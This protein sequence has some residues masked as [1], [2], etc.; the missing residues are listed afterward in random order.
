MKNLLQWAAVLLA[1]ASLPGLAPAHADDA[2]PAAQAFDYTLDNGMRVIV[3]PDHRA[4]VVVTMVWYRVGA[5]DEKTGVTG[6]AHVLEHMMFKGTPQVPAG[7]FSRLIAAAGGRENA[8]T[9]LDATAYFQTLQK[10]KLALALKLEAD[11]MANLTLSP[12]EFKR[13]IQVVMEERRWRVEDQSRA[14][15]YEQLMAT[16]FKEHPYRRPGIGWMNDL[17]HMTVGDVRD[18][19]ERWYAPNN[20]I[21][22]VVGDVEPQEVLD[23]AKQS[24]GPVPSRALP[25]R[26]AQV[27]PPQRGIQRINVKAPAELPYLV[28]AY[29][30]PALRQPREDWEPYAMEMLA[31]VLDGNPAARLN[32]DLVRKAHVATS[33]DVSYDDVGRGPSLFILSAM[34]TSGRS[35][36]DLEQA[37]RRELARVADDGV[38]PEELERVKA[39]AVAAHVYERD[40]VFFQ[41]QQIG[42]LEIAGLSHRDIDLFL[43]KL[44]AV[45]PEQVQAVAK[46]YL[47]DD[48]LTVATLDPQ[49]LPEGRPAAPPR[50]IDHG[51]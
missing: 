14:L 39:Q 1:A 22:V 16:A 17:Q 7:Q 18:F 10:S 33:L 49:P 20:A 44:K 15:L 41:A 50:G 42:G 43:Q 5:I 6:V 37:L 32:R 35:A 11:R 25:V 36:A 23:L 31:Y 29:H 30:A 8:F 27:E 4:P 46:K 9:S 21:L 47:V 45:T 19:Y 34:P 2:A 48:G 12:G 24:F 51:R 26:K 28:M 40:S 13:E 38:S 3:K